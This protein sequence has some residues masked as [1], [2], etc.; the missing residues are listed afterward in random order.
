MFANIW[1]MSRR[2][3][4]QSN[5]SLPPKHTQYLEASRHSQ[6][7]VEMF[8]FN[9]NSVLQEL[10]RGIIAQPLL[11]AGGGGNSGWSCNKDSILQGAWNRVVRKTSINLP[12]MTPTASRKLPSMNTA[13]LGDSDFAKGLQS[14][15]LVSR[16]S[17]AHLSFPFSKLE[18]SWWT[19]FHWH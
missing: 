19:Y 8:L 15:I 7:F 18:C 2:R 4:A 1:C 14:P 6:M 17:W 10:L 13:A 9:F 3:L 16:A 12:R 5:P 11:G